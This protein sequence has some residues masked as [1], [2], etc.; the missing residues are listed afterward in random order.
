MKRPDLLFLMHTLASGSDCDRRRVNRAGATMPYRPVYDV[1]N[2]GPPWWGLVWVIL[3][4]LFACMAFLEI[5][6]RLRGKSTAP[7][8]VPGRANMVDLPFAVATAI[9]LLM[10]VLAVLCASFTYKAFALWKQ[11][12]AWERAGEYRITEGTVADYN[13][14]KAGS[15]F[16]VGD[17][18]FDLLNAYAGFTGRFNVPGA[19]QDSL[20]DGMRVRLAQREGLILRVEIAVEPGAAP[21]RGRT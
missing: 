14:R 17:Q 11:C 2:D 6:Q 13:F 7:M 18:S 10:V 4:L 16:R 5:V 12:Q 15:S 3:P 9:G 1:L 19:P 20:A 8:R 21:D